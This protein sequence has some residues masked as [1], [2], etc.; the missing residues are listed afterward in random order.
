MYVWADGVFLQARMEYHGECR[1]VLISAMPEGKK[2][3]IGFQVGV[4]ESAQSWRELLID[5]KQRGLQIAPEIALGAGALG[6]RKASTRSF[7]A[8]VTSMLGTQDRQRPGQ[9]PALSVHVT[10]KK[11][12]R[13]VYWAPRRA[14]AEAAIDVLAEK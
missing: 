3:L 14:S 7:P 12:L 9:S 8:H 10:M 2:E 6:F 1:L 5:V 4:R 13:E 11:D